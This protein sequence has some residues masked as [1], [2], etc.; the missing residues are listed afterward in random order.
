MIELFIKT[1]RCKAN[2]SAEIK[3]LFSMNQK[4]K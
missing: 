1:V 2:K 3:I 4:L